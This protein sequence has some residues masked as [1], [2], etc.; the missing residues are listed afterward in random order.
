MIGL[1]IDVGAD[2]KLSYVTGSGTVGWTQTAVS[3]SG[4]EYI[5]EAENKGSRAD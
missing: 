4:K 5:N 2:E 1:K 3:V